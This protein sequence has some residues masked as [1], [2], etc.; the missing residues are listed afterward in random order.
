MLAKDKYVFFFHVSIPE[1][2]F[3]THNMG[4]GQ[5]MSGFPGMLVNANKNSWM[6]Y[7]VL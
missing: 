4:M 5:N 3:G 7:T 2:C 1:K 6:I